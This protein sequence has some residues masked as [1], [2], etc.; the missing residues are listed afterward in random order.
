MA[1][2]VSCHKHFDIDDFMDTNITESDICPDCYYGGGMVEP[3]DNGVDPYDDDV[4]TEDELYDDDFEEDEDDRLIQ[5]VIGSNFDDIDDEEFDDDEFADED[6]Y[7]DRLDAEE[8]DY[9][10][11]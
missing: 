11:S 8:G 9:E 10:E 2:C 6:D 4:D 5:S 7:E 1:Y 3:D